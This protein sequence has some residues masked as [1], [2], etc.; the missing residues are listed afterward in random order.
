[1]YYSHD[2]LLDSSPGRRCGDHRVVA[3]ADRVVSLR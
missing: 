2:I 1:L 3:A